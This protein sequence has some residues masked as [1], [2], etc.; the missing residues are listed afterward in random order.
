MASPLPNPEEVR[1][2]QQ[3]ADLL[4]SE[5]EVE[6]A[7]DGMAAAMTGRLAEL[8]PL[9]LGVMVGG[10]APLGCLLRRLPFHCRWITCTRRVIAAGSGAG[11]SSGGQD[12]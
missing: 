5:R 2:V 10:M 11:G 8:D 6:A 4:H 7:L 12:P 3:E 9:L 1:R